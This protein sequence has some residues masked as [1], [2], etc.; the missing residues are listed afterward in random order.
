VENVFNATMEDSVPGVIAALAANNDI[1]LRGKHVDNLAL[2]FV[3]P[4]RS[5]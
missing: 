4:L 3:A 2:T 1:N 5:N